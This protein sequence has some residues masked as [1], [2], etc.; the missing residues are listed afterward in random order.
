MPEIR[1]S[2]RDEFDAV[3]ALVGEAFTEE[4]AVVDLVRELAADAS[5]LPQ[6][7]LVAE[8][9]G[10]LVG[11]VLF[12]R[13]H[14]GGPL[15]APAI[16]CLAPLAVRPSR[17]GAGVGSALVREGLERARAAGERAVVV[18]GDPDYYGRFGFGPAFAHG[19]TPPHPV[20]M[21]EAWMV[22]ELQGDALAGAGG[23]VHFGDPLMDAKY[24]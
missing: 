3:L 22:L 8:D 18:L 4:P 11:Y 2:R 6:L 14:V 13:A 7:S 23:A 19:L 5:F 21:P 10:E 24:W 17:Q 1:T 20:E 15:D 9:A 12:T 16:A